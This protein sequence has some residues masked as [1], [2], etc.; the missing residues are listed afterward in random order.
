MNEET[1]IFPLPAGAELHAQAEALAKAAWLMGGPDESA[2]DATDGVDSKVPE[3]PPESTK[4]STIEPSCE[5]TPERSL[6]RDSAPVN[7]AQLR[8]P[9][10]IPGC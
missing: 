7:P 10:P 9:P 1:T 6:L 8:P 2:I 3:I 4:D 5:G